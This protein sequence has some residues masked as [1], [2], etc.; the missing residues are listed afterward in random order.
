MS[1]TGQENGSIIGDMMGRAEYKVPN[2]KL[3]ATESE[4]RDGTLVKIKITG[5]FFFAPGDPHRESRRKIDRYP[6][7]GCGEHCR[8][9]L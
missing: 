9:L 1:D 2:G 8:E 4:I 7:R 5:D 6:H 3:L